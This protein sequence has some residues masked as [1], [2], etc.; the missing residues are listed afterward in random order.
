MLNLRNIKWCCWWSWEPLF[1]HGFSACLS[2]SFACHTLNH[3]LHC[4]VF[5]N[6]NPEWRRTFSLSLLIQMM[7]QC[8]Y[9]LDLSLSHHGLLLIVNIFV[10]CFM[11]GSLLQLFC[12]WT[13]LVVTMFG[14][15]VYPTVSLFS[16]FWMHHNL[17]SWICYFNV[18][19]FL[20]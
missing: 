10:F 11:L 17:N 15:F 5:L 14:S 18:Q 2:C 3:S 13:I 7:S 1:W 19:S 8:K 4:M 12:R 9:I 20:T 16:N 6:K